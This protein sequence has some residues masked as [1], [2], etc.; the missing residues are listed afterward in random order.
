MCAVIHRLQSEIRSL[1]SDR[2]LEDLRRNNTSK[3]DASLIIQKLIRKKRKAESKKVRVHGS[4]GTNSPSLRPAIYRLQPALSMSATRRQTRQRSPSALPSRS[5]A[6]WAAQCRVSNA[7]SSSYAASSSAGGGESSL[8]WLSSL[9]AASAARQ[10]SMAA[11]ARHA[12]VSSDQ[13]EASRRATH[14][15]WLACPPPRRTPPDSPAAPRW[16]P[17]SGRTGRGRCP[18]RAGSWRRCWDPARTP[19]GTRS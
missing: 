13:Q 3:A 5:E 2:F 10:I 19:P 17:R 9:R 8:S 15:Q 1:K 11:A 4:T 12:C 6:T 16:R 7:A 18:G 14:P